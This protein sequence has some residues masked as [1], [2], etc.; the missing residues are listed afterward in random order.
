MLIPKARLKLD[1]GRAA[2][3]LD[4]AVI[5]GTELMI[6]M[7]W[8][9]V[10]VTLYGSGSMHFYHFTDAAMGRQL[11]LEILSSIGD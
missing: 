10:Q 5:K 11:A 4:D 7:N 8:K 2:I 9:G 1:M 6:Q 3:A